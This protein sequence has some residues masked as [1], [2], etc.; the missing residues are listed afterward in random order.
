MC[1][2]GDPKFLKSTTLKHYD[3][4]DISH[5]LTLKWMRYSA[6]YSEGQTRKGDTISDQVNALH[7]LSIALISPGKKWEHC[8]KIWTLSNCEASVSLVS[9][10]QR[11]LTRDFLQTACVLFMLCWLKESLVPLKHLTCLGFPHSSVGKE[12]TCNAEDPSSIPGLGRS[13]GEGIGYPLQYSWAF[14]VA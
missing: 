12:S 11:C 14:L 2:P 4:L 5:H 3:P 7:F 10:Q 8:L 13:P 9:F 1:T 6:H